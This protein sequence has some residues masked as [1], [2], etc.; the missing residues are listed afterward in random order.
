MNCEKENCIYNRDFRCILDK[1]NVY[2]LDKC[3]FYINVKLAKK[4]LKAE[5]ERQLREIAES[6]LF[7]IVGK[8][9]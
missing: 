2:E 8:K 6:F 9:R 1:S 3:K 7:N 4:F 5:K